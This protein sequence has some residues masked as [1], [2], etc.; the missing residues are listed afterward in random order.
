M[1]SIRPAYGR[2]VVP[3]FRAALRLVR[4]GLA[5]ALLVAATFA[6]ALA[7]TAEEWLTE[8]EQQYAKPDLVQA[9]ASFAAA[10]QAAPANAHALCRL[11]RAESEIG[12]LQKGNEQRMTWAAAVEHART[13]VRAAPE[14]AEP[15]VRLAVA[16]G[17]QALR[18]GPKAKLALSR[19]IKAEVDRALALDPEHP[20]A[21]HVLAVWNEKLASLNAFERM[22]A[23]VVLGGVPKGASFENAERAFKKAIALAPDDVNHRL[24]YGELL[25][26][27][28]RPADARRELEKAVSLPPTS[29]A[30]DARYQAEA[31]EVLA[32]L[33]K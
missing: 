4:P 33:P 32:K 6:P 11:A 25:R 3:A 26:E 29:S 13:A 18:E 27:M 17:R 22:A 30:I 1:P 2:P 24:A 23:N 8:G 14:T 31:R 10:V 21:W 16:L 5:A 15:H 7:K 12:E 9:R 20:S 28:H 19:E